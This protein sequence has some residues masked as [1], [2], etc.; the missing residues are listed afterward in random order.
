MDQKEFR[1]ALGQFATGVTV[2]TTRDS[3]GKP[4]GVTANSFNS[5]SLDPPMVLWSLAKSAH[6]MSAF[7]NAD[8]FAVHILGSDQQDISNRF[9]SRGADKFAGMD[10]PTDGVPTIENCAARFVCR[11]MHQY[12][13]G[14]HIIFV[15][16]VV[17][18]STEDK[19]PLLY[20]SG[21]YAEKRRGAPSD[22]DGIDLENA[23]VGTESL[24]HLLARAYTQITRQLGRELDACDMAQPRLAIM[25]AVGHNRDATRSELSRR[26][27]SSGFAVADKD[28]DALIDLGWIRDNAGNLDMTDHGRAQ[29]L[30]ALSRVASLEQRLG[31]GLSDSEL[32]EARYVLAS[33]IENT[34]DG[35]PS[36]IR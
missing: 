16:K 6:S 24:T 36:L 26:I 7:A 30:E 14:D 32:A 28:F 21:R 15:G 9:A 19:E 8:R 1:S 23:Q 33:I 12:E 25:L 27:T 13:G 3:K 17:D 34:S 4:V 5:V 10:F 22:T 35:I 11:T 31:E 2:V 20:V 18:F 29:Y